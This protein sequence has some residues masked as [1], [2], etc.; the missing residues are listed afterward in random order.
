[1]SK[2]ICIPDNHPGLRKELSQ[3]EWD[4]LRAIAGKKVSS[5]CRMNGDDTSLL[6]FPD[7][8]DL[9][10]DKIGDEVVFDIFEDRISS[11]NLMGFIG[12]RDTALKIHSRFDKGGD[13]FFMHYMLEKVF[14]VNMF[15]LPHSTDTE[16]IFDFIIFLFPYF[17][18]QALAQGLYR[19]Y[20]TYRRNN[21]H[22]RGPIDIARHIRENVPFSGS[23]SYNSREYTGDNDLIELIRHTIEYIRTKPFG[24]S[25]LKRDESTKG[26]VSDIIQATP[27]YNSNERVKVIYRN[28]RPKIHPY[29]SEYEPLRRLCLQILREEEIKYGEQDDKVYGVLFDGAWLWEAYLNTLFEGMNIH[30]PDNKTG[31]GKIYLF[32]P[33]AAPRYPDFW[34]DGIVMDAKYKG[35]D[36]KSVTQVGREDLAQVI[37][38]MYIKNAQLGGFLVPGSN[39]TNISS[40]KLNS[41]LGGEMFLLSLPIPDDAESYSSFVNQIEVSESFF[42]SKIRDLINCL[43]PERQAVTAAM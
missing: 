39:G 2:P 5:L 11:G 26:C 17:L 23:I 42:V 43:V 38:Y 29:Y 33:K 1:M 14:A 19:Q 24:N 40:A 16:D 25:I 15:D 4:D 28:L 21:S 36:G 27:S 6:V 3:I 7:S 35:Y 34:G 30:H 10:G 12:R 18:K 37:S 20:I 31:Q 41:A 22:V 8:L 32:T 9:Y 13:D